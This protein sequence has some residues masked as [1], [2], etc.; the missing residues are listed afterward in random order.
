MFEPLCKNLA[1]DHHM[2]A[3]S[4]QNN[5]YLTFIRF[6]IHIQC[7]VSCLSIVLGVRTVRQFR[8]SRAVKI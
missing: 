2:W 8:F 7:F 6:S 4:D 3:D 5:L 1:E